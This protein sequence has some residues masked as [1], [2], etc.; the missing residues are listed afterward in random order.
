M[1]AAFWHQRWQAGQIGF[2]QD[3]PTPLLLRHWPTL[4][5]PAGGKVFVPLAGK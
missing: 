4:Q 5:V 1:D 3:A 2:H